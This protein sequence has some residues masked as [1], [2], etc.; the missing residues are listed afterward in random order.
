MK[1]EATQRYRRTEKGVLTNIY[2]HILER[3]RKNGFPEPDF[4]C[5]YLHQRFL[6]DK[7]YLRIYGDW[8]ISGFQK[9]M[10]PSIDRINNKKPY[11]KDN[12]QILSWAENRFK[13]SM[14]RR[15]RKGEVCQILNGKIITTFRSQRDAC[16]KLNLGQS[17]LSM[18]LTGKTKTA[19][20]YEWKYKSEIIGNVHTEEKD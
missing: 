18:A 9:N 4:D 10:K 8:I 1:Y 12:I 13:Q 16:N 11:T 7:K 5:K 6:S 19:Y 14:E 3:S 15:S 2:A 20:G 17:M